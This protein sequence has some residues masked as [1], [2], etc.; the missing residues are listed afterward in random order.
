MSVTDRCGHR[1]SPDELPTGVTPRTCDRATWGSSVHCVWHADS[2]NKLESDLPQDE[3]EEGC[4]IDG[5]ILKDMEFSDSFSFEG[6]KLYNAE[7]QDSSLVSMDFRESDLRGADF[8]DSELDHAKFGGNVFADNVTFDGASLVDARFG[9]TRLSNSHFK[10]C[11]ALS[12]HF[13]DARLMQ[14]DFSNADLRDADFR[15]ANLR[16]ADLTETKLLNSEFN[17]AKLERADMSKADLREATI[18]DIESHECDFRDVRVDHR[19][20]F[21]EICIYEEKSDEEVDTPLLDYQ[22]LSNTN[23]RLFRSIRHLIRRSP[24]HSGEPTEPDYL[25]KAIWS[26][27]DF[28]RIAQE[29][30]LPDERRKFSIR[31]KH[32]QRKRAYSN[33]DSYRWFKLALSHRGMLY[34]ESPWH[35]IRTSLLSIVAFS[36]IFGITGLRSSKTGTIYSIEPKLAFSVDA[37][38]QL[39]QFSITRFLAAS[40][41]GHIPLGYGAVLATVESALGAFLIALFVFVLGRRATQ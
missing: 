39:L 9:G 25:M 27:R 14:A 3:V 18:T 17:G 5:A 35:V 13:D 28:Q 29:N 30:S 36:I 37:F 32:A 1:L 31:E 4:R 38:L 16:S 2:D 23:F 40:N 33:G 6:C 20:V 21:D 19:T 15:G 12:A 41:A 10:N 34:G 26:Y 8:S 7:F 22:L 11:E 24:L